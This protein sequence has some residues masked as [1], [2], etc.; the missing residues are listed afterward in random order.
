MACLGLIDGLRF[1]DRLSL[2]AFVHDLAS[3]VSHTLSICSLQV[4]R[5]LSIE[6]VLQLL[7]L[8][9][10]LNFVVTEFRSDFHNLFIC[11]LIP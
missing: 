4:D 2:C 5:F 7:C 3:E 8:L 9:G 6:L 10:S 11:L 1:G